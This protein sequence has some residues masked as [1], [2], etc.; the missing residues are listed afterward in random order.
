MLS[1]KII[2]QRRKSTQNIYKITKTMELVATAKLKIAV[3]NLNNFLAYRQELYLMLGIVAGGN[4][5][6]ALLKPYPT[7]SKVIILGLASHK[8]LCGSYNTRLSNE[9][10]KFRNQLLLDHHEVAL[11]VVGRKLAQY[12][13]YQDVPVATTY[14]IKDQPQFEDLHPIAQT[15]MQNFVQ[16][17]V[18]QVWIVYMR[19]MRIVRELLLPFT[20][21]QIPQTTGQVER[22]SFVPEPKQMLESLLPMTV[23]LALHQ[24]LLEAAI[25]EQTARMLAMKTAS[26]NAEQMIKKLTRQYNRARQTQITKEILEVIGGAEK[27]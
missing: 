5:E 23:E 18:H 27:K 2:K 14:N 19:K 20:I 6:H 22:Y 12:F 7:V 13:H 1:G 8:S 15:L 17:Q 4:I 25:S 9:M 16:S 24:S 3:R 11:H 26:E 10:I 21:P